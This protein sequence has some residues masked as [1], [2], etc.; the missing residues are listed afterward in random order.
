MS[1]LP[2]RFT[3]S[4]DAMLEIGGP[5]RI[6]LSHYPSRP[7]FAEV[8]TALRAVNAPFR[9]ADPG[10]KQVPSLGAKA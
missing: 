7:R 4:K 9:H 1:I 5:R 3:A 2:S 10:L 6:A 8:G